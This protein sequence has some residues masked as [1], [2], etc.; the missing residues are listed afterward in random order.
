MRDEGYATYPIGGTGVWN[1]AVGTN[2]SQAYETPATSKNYPPGSFGV[3]PY[4]NDSVQGHLQMVYDGSRIVSSTSWG[5]QYMAQ[6]DVSGGV[7]GDGNYGW[8]GPNIDRT[9]AWSFQYIDTPT[10]IGLIPGVPVLDGFPGYNASAIDVCRWYAKVCQWW[11]NMPAIIPLV[12][13]GVELTTVLSKNRSYSIWEID[14]YS[15]AVDHDSYGQHQQRWQYYPFPW[16][17]ETSAWSFLARVDQVLGQ[18]AY[19][20]A[21]DPKAVGELVQEAQQSA[22]PDRYEEA[23]EWVR[24]LLDEAMKGEPVE[25]EKPQKPPKPEESGAWWIGFSTPDPNG[26]KWLGSQNAPEGAWVRPT[27]SGGKVWLELVAP[28]AAKPTEGK[29]AA[30]EETISFSGEGD[31]H[32]LSGQLKIA[33]KEEG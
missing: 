28:E 23:Y 24:P 32:R 3:T 33:P 21:D 16:D 29:P 11:T 7:S 31:T 14:G 10:W 6:S 30:I 18:D 9:M 2:P 26:V 27:E 4:A 13:I 19:P 17:F 15:N 20:A 25:P 5:D 22:Y 12:C 1:A 8:P